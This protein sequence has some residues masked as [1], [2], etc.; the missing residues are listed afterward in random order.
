MTFP[1]HL[2]CPDQSKTSA[3]YLQGEPKKNVISKDMTITALKSIR[4]GKCWCVLENSGH[5]LRCRIG[6]KPFKFGG[7]MAKKQD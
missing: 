3:L 4:K 6:T 1:P 2:P 5:M 7:K